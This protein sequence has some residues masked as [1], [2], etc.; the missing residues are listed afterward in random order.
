MSH[1]VIDHNVTIRRRRGGPE[2]PSSVVPSTATFEGKRAPGRGTPRAKQGSGVDEELLFVSAAART[3]GALRSATEQLPAQRIAAPR[4]PGPGSNPTSPRVRPAPPG[5]AHRVH[6]RASP[7]RQRPHLA[8][9]SEG[10]ERGSAASRDNPLPAAAPREHR[11]PL[12]PRGAARCWMRARHLPAAGP[13]HSG[14][15]LLQKIGRE[16]QKK[17]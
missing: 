10:W 9:G 4:C 12:L 7:E 15:V 17:F 5:H 2:A 6:P 3:E 16:L 8:G 11:S 14:A 13:Q 1:A